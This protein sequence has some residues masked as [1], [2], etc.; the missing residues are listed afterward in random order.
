MGYTVEIKV[1]KE[2]GAGFHVAMSVALATDMPERDLKKKI[3]AL[4]SDLADY[5]AP[6]S[7]PASKPKEYRL[8]LTSSLEN[9]NSKIGLIKEI[10][11]IT[12]LGLKEAKD[13]VEA[14]RPTFVVSSSDWK[15]ISHFDDLIKQWGCE[16]AIESVE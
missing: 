13:L 4:L 3:M 1:T 10:R 2:S 15:V 14:P 12:G 9:F 6:P 16:T 11:T 5:E 7:A 8:Y